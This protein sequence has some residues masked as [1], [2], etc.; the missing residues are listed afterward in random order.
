MICQISWPMIPKKDIAMKIRKKMAM[1]HRE[2]L[3]QQIL[4]SQ[5]GKKMPATAPTS[6]VK[7]RKRAAAA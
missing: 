4:S 3:K 6:D 1:E 2:L 5:R 7:K